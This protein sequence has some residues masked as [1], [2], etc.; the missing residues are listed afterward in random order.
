MSGVGFLWIGVIFGLVAL[1]C[2]LIF[3]F[4]FLDLFL[5]FFPEPGLRPAAQ[6]PYF[7][8]KNKVTQQKLTLLLTTLR[9]APGNLPQSTDPARRGTPAALS[10]SGQTAAA[11]QWLKL[12][13]HL[14]QQPPDRL[15]EAG[16]IRRD[17]GAGFDAQLFV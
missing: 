10:R 1:L 15:P 6:L 12:L 16:V 2:L 11:S 17:W 7:C 14:T 4:R 8:Q 5:G 13:R 9:C 3:G